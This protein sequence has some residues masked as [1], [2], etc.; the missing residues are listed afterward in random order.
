[1]VTTAGRE[2][3]DDAGRQ[4]RSRAENFIVLGVLIALVIGAGI[5]IYE[6]IP[7]HPGDDSAEAGFLRDM[8][9][10]HN[11]AVEMA[12]IIHDRTDNPAL[13][14][15]TTDMVLTQASQ[16]GMMQGWLNVWGVAATGDDP[17]M[18]WMGSPVPAGQ[19][20]PGMADT[21]EVAR[22][23]TLPSTDAEV[24]FLQL[25]IRHHQGGVAMAE[26][27]AQTTSQTQ[28]RQ[29]ADSIVMGQ[30]NEMDAMNEM[31]QARGQPAITAPLPM[32][33]SGH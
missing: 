13:K 5:F 30:Q 20:M 17:A 7:R 15:L 8:I 14:M 26:A 2:T 24:L 3:G 1:M 23:R 6:A 27:I 31:L 22:L 16:I 32:D 18:T 29:L 11:Q 25:M 28:V 4:A 9:T 12:M 33:M 21:G 10:H 19:V